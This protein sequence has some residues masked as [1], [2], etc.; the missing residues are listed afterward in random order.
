MEVDCI[1]ASPALQSARTITLL[2]LLGTGPAFP[3][4]FR[5]CPNAVLVGP[6]RP[7]VSAK[8]LRPAFDNILNMSHGCRDCQ[9]GS[10][11]LFPATGFH[12]RANHPRGW[13]AKPWVPLGSPGCRK[14]F[15]LPDESDRWFLPSSICGRKALRFILPGPDLG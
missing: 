5:P 15:S 1:P 11:P 9:E 3:G 2:S 8:S 12:E 10:R 7:E 14:V 4:F 13:D 6:E